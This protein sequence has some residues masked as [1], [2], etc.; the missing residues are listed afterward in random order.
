MAESRATRTGFGFPRSCCTNSCGC[1]DLLTTKR[2]LARFPDVSAL[3]SSPEQEL[4]A[5]WAGLVIIRGRGICNGPLKQ[6]WNWAIFRRITHS[7]RSLP[8]VGD[9]TASAIASIA[10]DLPHAVLD[11]NVLR[12]LSRFTGERGNV[13]SPGSA[14]PA[15]NSCRTT[16]SPDALGRIQSGD[17]GTRGYGVSSK[18]SRD[19]RRAPC[20]AIVWHGSSE[21][22]T[23]HRCRSPNQNPSGQAPS[24]W[25]RS[26]L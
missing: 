14:K 5:A 4:L 24:V 25:R 2:F 26:C 17:D 1:G 6:S 8:G 7:L 23:S 21:S 19:A 20:R 16:A 13:D 9:Y 10:F 12:A 15:A 18:S 22:R 3:A 11:G